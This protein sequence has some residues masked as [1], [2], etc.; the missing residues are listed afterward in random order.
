MDK[1]ELID[2]FYKFGKISG[3]LDGLMVRIDG[4]EVITRDELEEVTCLFKETID[5][6]FKKVFLNGEEN[7]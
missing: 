2:I 7:K 1:L 6:L 3:M 5:T 4:G